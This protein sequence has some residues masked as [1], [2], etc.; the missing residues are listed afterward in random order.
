MKSSQDQSTLLVQRLQGNTKI[1][2][3]ITKQGQRI[4]E[5]RGIK[6]W[7]AKTSSF[8]GFFWW[9]LL[10]WRLVI[11]NISEVPLKYCVN[12]FC[13][14]QRGRGQRDPGNRQQLSPRTLWEQCPR[15]RTSLHTSCRSISYVPD[16]KQSMEVSLICSPTPHDVFLY[17]WHTGGWAHCGSH[18]SNSA[19]RKASQSQ[20]EKGSDW[21]NIQVLQ[22]LWKLWQLHK[23]LISSIALM[24]LFNQSKDACNSS[25]F[26]WIQT[27]ALIQYMRNVEPKLLQYH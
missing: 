23:L 18:L 3:N 11:W 8:V 7:I 22:Q 17:H 24:L 4:G 6:N 26:K 15:H 13:L 9:G 14:E 27:A 1:C 19:I 10:E 16:V 5:C 25:D 21:Q 12:A 2:F 20:E